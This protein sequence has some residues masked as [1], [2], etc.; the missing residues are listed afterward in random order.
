[1]LIRSLRIASL[2]VALGALAAAA[3]VPRPA[4]PLEM[5]A[6]DGRMISLAAL[7]GRPVLVMYFST[8]CPHCQTAAAA[9]APIYKE[10]A[11]KGVEFLGLALNPTAKG[12]LGGFADQ[13]RVEFPVGLA[14]RAH[15]SRFTGLSVMTRFYYPYFVFVDK[16]GVIQEERDGALRSYFADLDASLRESLARIAGG[17]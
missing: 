7:K 5:K 17:S 14:D 6:I 1:M 2:S 8:D 3:D 4:G 16:D 15:F 12:N 13:Y 11:P 9:M 10:M